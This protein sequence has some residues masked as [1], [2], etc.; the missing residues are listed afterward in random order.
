M[1]RQDTSECSIYIKMLVC[2]YRIAL[3]LL[4]AAGLCSYA[5]LQ[6][7]SAECLLALTGYAV[8]LLVLHGIYQACSVGQQKISELI[9]SQTLSNLISA[10]AIY[11]CVSLY[12][13]DLLNPLP[14]LVVIILQGLIGTVWSIFVNRLYYSHYVAPHTAI[15]Y[16]SEA[17]LQQLC[18]TPQFHQK[19]NVCK[20]IQNP[21]DD[22]QRLIPELD[23]CEVVFAVD[24]SA[25]LT[26]E[27]AKFCVETGIKGF[28]VPRLGH[29][30]MSGAEYMSR[31]SM[32]MLKVQRAGEQSVYC[33]CKRVFD[34]V[35]SLAGIVLTSPVMLATALCIRHEDH[36][37]V[38]YRQTRLT[39]NGREFSILKFR[40][41]TIDAE[42]DGVA[43][44][45]SE[46]DDRITRVGRFIRA[47]RI[48]E[49]PQLFNIL[50][51]DMSIVGPRPE[52]PEIA[53]QYEQELPEFG[54][55]LQV[56][57]GLTGMAQVYGRYN[58]EP[59]HKLQ[60]DLMYINQMS[61]MTDLK[62]IVATLKILFVKESTAGV[63]DSQTTAPH[64]EEEKCS[65]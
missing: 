5:A 51:G 29:I 52:R 11:L 59:Y 22:I 53:K 9:L 33:A 8:L 40:S 20:L 30:V 27:L 24:I 12:L 10:G 36:G 41:M 63:Q 3:V 48:D 7:S 43:R 4:M 14:L 21:E 45:A 38:F 13:H 26:N 54:L 55:R 34:V 62:F 31:F 2:F 16:S 60:M 56:K 17:L 6:I 25:K 1:R 44:L 64:T 47:Y 39:R 57:A 49:L 61:F 32:P 18:A 65:V 46:N 42:Q 19:Y 23:G 58:T 37:P 28:F 50:F 15:V 35:V